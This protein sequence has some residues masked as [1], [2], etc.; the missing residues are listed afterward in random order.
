MGDEYD[1]DYDYHYFDLIEDAMQTKL[2]E[3]IGPE[4]VRM[5]EERRGRDPMCKLLYAMYS[6]AR[7]G[8]AAA[9]DLFQISWRVF[10]QQRFH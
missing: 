5:L 3:L 6:K 1:E 8:D 4:E 9:L 2:D 7:E 10:K